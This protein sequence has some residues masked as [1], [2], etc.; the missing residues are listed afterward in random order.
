MC[1]CKAHT[2]SFQTKV[3]QDKAPSVSCAPDRAQSCPS[4]AVGVSGNPWAQALWALSLISALPSG[5][6]F[7]IGQ[8]NEESHTSKR[9]E[10]IRSTVKSCH[11]ALDLVSR[12]AKRR[13]AVWRPLGSARLT[14]HP[15]RFCSMRHSLHTTL[16]VSKGSPAWQG[17]RNAALKNG[18]IENSVS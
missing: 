13:G 11:Q 15:G 17:D 18:C 14:S 2:A 5:Q 10:K 7:S 1:L 12:E 3:S 4:G 9:E 6:M 8:L 16:A